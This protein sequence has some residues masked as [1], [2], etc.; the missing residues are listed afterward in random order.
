MQPFRGFH[1]LV[2]Q[3][4]LD[5]HNLGAQSTSRLTGAATFGIA[6]SPGNDLR[7]NC[8]RLSALHGE[9]DKAFI[10]QTLVFGTNTWSDTGTGVSRST[11]RMNLRVRMMLEVLPGTGGQ[12]NCAAVE[13]ASDTFSISI[14]DTGSLLARQALSGTTSTLATAT[15]GIVPGQ[16]FELRLTRD[17]TNNALVYAYKKEGESSWT[18]IYSS[19][20]VPGT[21]AQ[22][23]SLIRLGILGF[24]GTSSATTCIVWVD[25]FATSNLNFNDTDRHWY[26]AGSGCRDANQTRANPVIIYPAELFRNATQARVEYA[27]N[28]SFTGAATSSWT[29]LSNRQHSAL[30]LPLTGLTP[31]T[32]Y[33]YRFQIGDA[34]GT[35]LFTSETYKFRTF[36]LK[37]AEWD[38]PYAFHVASCIYAHSGA[39]PYNDLEPVTNL[40]NT[41]NNRWLGTWFQGDWGYEEGNKFDTLIDPDISVYETESDFQQ[42]CR[43][44][45]C[46]IPLNEL[47]KAGVFASQADDHEFINDRDA[48]DAPGGPLASTAATTI[49]SRYSD[50]LTVSQIYSNGYSV[51]DAWFLNH[52]IGLQPYSAISDGRYFS[53]S[54]GTTR[55]LQID[56]RRERRP[57]LSRFVSPAQLSWLNAEIAAFGSDPVEKTLYIFSAGGFSQFTSK[58]GESW[59]FN[60]LTE[61]RNLMTHIYSS[62]PPEK[63]VI[64]LSGDDHLGYWIHNKGWN[65][66]AYTS[67]LPFAGEIKSSSI[68]SGYYRPSDSIVSSNAI[69]TRT[70]LNPGLANNNTNVLRS[71]GIVVEQN[72]EGTE[73]LIQFWYNGTQN[74][75]NFSLARNAPSRLSTLVGVANVPSYRRG[76]RAA[77]R[78]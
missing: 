61:Y 5:M 42:L 21:T 23:V 1:T 71:S 76:R 15:A 64:I 78:I 66:G 55:W 41:T 53:R 68:C 12:C 60:A 77:R 54:F 43:E 40:A 36:P 74:L 26:I 10:Y 39:H 27:T 17:A 32:Q 16:W 2:D 63:R 56:V 44:V 35:V 8:L 45:A 69:Y 25:D 7:G 72:A 33:Y 29:P 62:V 59:E 6:E 46:D 70:R 14:T 57:D 67:A 22:G 18:T 28:E 65:N 51:Y 37:G 19:G 49:D 3:I 50:G 34:G 4:S 24:D 20:T 75:T 9:T 48:R 30:G 52:F 47:L 11:P 58:S 31:D 73:I 13:T 38:I